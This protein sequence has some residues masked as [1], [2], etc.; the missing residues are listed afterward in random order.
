MMPA[1]RLAEAGLDVIRSD[2]LDAEYYPSEVLLAKILIVED[3][4]ETLDSLTI[5]LELADYTVVVA[6]DGHEALALLPKEKPDLVITDGFLPGLGGIDLIKA[7]RAS[8][9]SFRDTP[10]IMV[11]GYY[12]ELAGEAVKAGA[13]HVFSKPTNPETLLAKVKSLL[14]PAAFRAFR[15]KHD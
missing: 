4:P 7:M 14:N 15:A 2:C 9:T 10:I 12:A 5:W 6:R 11:T 13:N 1:I 3:H 8:L